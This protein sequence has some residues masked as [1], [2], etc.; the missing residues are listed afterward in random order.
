MP[1]QPKRTEW[2]Y[3]QVA[4]D[5]E[6]IKALMSDDRH[7]IGRDTSV[8]NGFYTGE[9]GGEAIV[10]NYD[11]I[12]EFYEKLADSA[13]DRALKSDGTVDKSLV[14]NS[15]YELVT[16]QM[17]Y[18]LDGVKEVN[19]KLGVTDFRKVSLSAY[20]SKNTGV[21]RHQAL[22]VATILEILKNRGVLNGAISVDRNLQWT[23]EGEQEGHAWAR[24]TSKA[25]QVFIL[26]VAHQFIGTL[27]QSQ[28]IESGWNYLRDEEKHAL[29]LILEFDAKD[30]SMRGLLRRLRDTLRS[31]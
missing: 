23:D 10:V 4:D 27:E 14:L 18:S 17:P 8:L 20:A 26:D 19:K 6:A 30:V 12:P 24:Y 29:T 1:K 9:Y 22:L 16:E 25:G 28:Q 3:T 11:A 31:V 7:R 15:V 13:L 5:I 2:S 21:C